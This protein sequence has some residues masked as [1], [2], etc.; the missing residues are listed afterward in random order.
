MCRVKKEYAWVFFE[1]LSTRKSRRG[2]RK[3][4]CLVCVSVMILDNIRCKVLLEVNNHIGPYKLT[5]NGKI[6][7][8]TGEPRRYTVETY[9]S[10]VGHYR[11]IGLVTLAFNF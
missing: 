8:T 9:A 1:H 4:V 7:E 3:S 10:A 2:S 5:F 11:L 6:Y